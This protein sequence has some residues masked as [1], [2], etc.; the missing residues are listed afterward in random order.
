M[1]KKITLKRFYDEFVS[2]KQ[3]VLEKFQIVDKRLSMLEAWYRKLEEIEVHVKK[4]DFLYNAV[5]SF[6]GEV[7]ASREERVFIGHRLGDHEKRISL[8]EQFNKQNKK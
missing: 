3:L 6:M 4:I 7:Q 5:D 2:F 8:L 1:P